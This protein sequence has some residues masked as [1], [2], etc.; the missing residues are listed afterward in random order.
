MEKKKLEDMSKPEL[1]ALVKKKNL[2]VTGMKKE[3]MINALKDAENQTSLDSASQETPPVAPETTPEVTSEE[4]VVAAPEGTTQSVF[5]KTVDE[6]GNVAAVKD[7]ISEHLKEDEEKRGPSVRTK[8]NTG[9]DEATHP[10]A[11]KVK[12]ADHMDSVYAFQNRLKEKR[13]KK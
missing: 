10:M 12:T 7:A 3:E 1:S 13:A 5:G 2:F 6:P 9:D 8:E 4:P 11:S